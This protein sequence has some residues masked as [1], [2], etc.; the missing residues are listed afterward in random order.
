MSTLASKIAQFAGDADKLHNVVHG[1][2]DGPDS[3]IATDGGT[4]PSLARGAAAFV[5]ADADAARAEA[6]R[7]AAQLSAGLYATTAAGLAATTS[8]QFFSVPAIGSADSIVLYRNDSGEAQEVSRYPRSGAVTAITGG[9]V[10]LSDAAGYSSQ[11]YFTA[12]GAWTASTAGYRTTGF[13]PVVPGETLSVSAQSSSGV[14]AVSYWRADKSFLSSVP[15]NSSDA[16]RSLTVP[17]GAAFARSSNNSGA[18]AAPFVRVTYQGIVDQRGL[19]AQ[20]DITLDVS[21]NL[22]RPEYLI[23][24]KYVNNIGVTV[25]GAGWKMMRIPVKAGKTYTFGNFSIDSSGYAAFQAENGSVLQIIGSYGVAHLLKT[26]TAP[27][28]D[29]Y[30]CIDIAR[31]VNTVE[32]YAET[33]V[34]EGAVLLP[35]VA[36][37]DKITAIKG[38]PI[39]GSGGIA[40][41]SDAELRNVSA[42]RVDA[43]E[44]ATSVLILNLPSGASEPAGLEVGQA[45]VDTSNGTIRVKQ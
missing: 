20:S 36:P 22:A 31:P 39:G 38:A 26:V 24:D 28:Q 3:L 8:G 42:E 15:G 45:W 43:A 16:A 33:M 41:G 32:H 10:T 1:P 9:T 2:A 19:L 29:C 25:S 18:L 6:A 21:I 14:A 27:A 30:L 4:I 12:A 7:D 44:L 17:A 35:Y 34:N 13:L 40:P 11:G 37:V 5:K 23:A